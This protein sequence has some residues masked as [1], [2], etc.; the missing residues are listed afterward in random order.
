MLYEDLEKIENGRCVTKDGGIGSGVK[1]HI[2]AEQMKAMKERKNFAKG[3]SEHDKETDTA[4]KKFPI[5]SLIRENR[6][7]SSPVKVIGHSGN[8][9]H[10]TK[11]DF[12]I[13]KMISA[14]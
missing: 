3:I 4:K 5:G 8:M 10:T 12:H 6:S 9:I 2:T 11:G 13:T 1:G 14:N 7:G